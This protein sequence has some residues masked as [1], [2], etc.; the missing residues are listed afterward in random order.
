[1]ES[2]MTKLINAYKTFPADIKEDIKGALHTWLSGVTALALIATVAL[3]GKA[4]AEAL[5]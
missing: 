3:Y 5:H 4:I 1:M 2:D